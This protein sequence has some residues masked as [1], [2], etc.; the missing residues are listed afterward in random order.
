MP[1]DSTAPDEATTEPREFRWQFSDGFADGRW[2]AWHVHPGPCTGCCCGGGPDSDGEHREPA[3]WYEDGG[4]S[5]GHSYLDPAD[6]DP[7]FT[8][9]WRPHDKNGLATTRDG[10]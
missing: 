7:W 4:L 3:E 5:P 6:P 1:E 10:Q 9:E 2:S 8:V